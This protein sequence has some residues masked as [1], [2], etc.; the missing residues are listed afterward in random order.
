MAQRSRGLVTGEGK[1]PSAAKQKEGD[2]PISPSFVEFHLP[3]NLGTVAALSGYLINLLF[4]T[5]TTWSLIE[6]QP[7]VFAACIICGFVPSIASLVVHIGSRIRADRE[8]RARNDELLRKQEHLKQ[9]ADSLIGSIDVVYTLLTGSHLAKTT[10]SDGAQLRLTLFLPDTKTMELRQVVRRDWTGRC[11]TSNTTVR[12]GTGVVGSAFVRQTFVDLNVDNGH[13]FT[14]T[15]R[16]LGIAPE[17]SSQHRRQ[18]ARYFAAIP[19]FDG[20]D[21]TPYDNKSMNYGRVV[22]V[23]AVDALVTHPLKQRWYIDTAKKVF[24]SIHNTLS[25]NTYKV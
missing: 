19:V 12:W 17:E 2:R 9:L 25:G 16:I 18:D 20:T 1:S 3:L 8:L 4:S 10:S 14:D 21:Q 13:A 15:V 6:S 24:P 11:A 23:L 5:S 7:I 22:A